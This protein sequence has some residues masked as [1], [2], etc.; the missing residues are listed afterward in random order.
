MVLN[1]FGKKTSTSQVSNNMEKQR[2]YEAL[3]RAWHRDLYRYAYWLT[4][5]QHVAEDLVQETCL[6]AWRSLD[7][8]KMIMQRKHG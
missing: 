2:R 8:F 7:S 4:K 1:F 5:D 3:V 6:R